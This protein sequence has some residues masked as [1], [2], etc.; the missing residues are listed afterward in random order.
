M[1]NYE[2][3][4]RE[5]VAKAE[6]KLKGYSFLGGMGAK[7]DD[8]AELLE[9]AGNNFKLAKA[10][11]DAGD[12]Y[13][14]L[15]EVH[16]KQDSKTD[17]AQAYVEASKAYQRVDKSNA[18]RCMHKAIGYYTDL[19]RLGMA[20]RNLREVAET[21]EKAGLKEECIEFYDK[22]AELFEVENQSSEANKCRLKIALFSAELERFPVAIEIYE[23]IAKSQVENNLLKYSAK[24]NL[25]NA[26]LCRLN[27][28]DEHTLRT[29]LERY[30]D[31]DVSYRGSRE[32][33]FLMALAEA[34]EVGDSQKFTDAIAEYDSMTRLDGWKTQLLLRVKKRLTDVAEGEEEDLT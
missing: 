15:A 3:K 8:A 10:W 4:A 17:A 31:I 22:A 26:G 28:D 12:T 7:Y 11:R 20:A 29:A 16:V 25:L 24:S 2:Y 5:M 21:Q 18:L 1:S 13:S 6:K 23:S 27:V 14:K 9:S 32:A 30:D 33:T 19:G 34:R